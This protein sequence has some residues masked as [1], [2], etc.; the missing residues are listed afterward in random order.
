MHSALPLFLASPSFSG[1]SW[2]SVSQPLTRPSP[3]LTCNLSS[4]PQRKPMIPTSQQRQPCSPLPSSQNAWQGPDCSPALATSPA[5]SCCRGS[6]WNVCLH[7]SAA[8]HGLCPQ[9]CLC[10]RCSPCRGTGQ[11][12]DKEAALHPHTQVVPPPQ[13][14]LWPVVSP[15][16]TPPTSVRPPSLSKPCLCDS[17]QILLP[18]KQE[19]L[20]HREMGDTRAGGAHVP[21]PSS[22]ICPRPQRLSPSCKP[23]PVAGWFLVRAA[24]LP[25][26][27]YVFVIQSMLALNFLFKAFLP[28]QLAWASEAIEAGSNTSVSMLRVVLF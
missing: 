2:C 26:C 24:S 22:K 10:D 11:G 21:L 20:Q 17:R 16:T 3:D 19:H 1:P 9:P 18:G 28:L 5:G 25:A 6:R 14:S 7:W 4:S 23:F 12:H 13:H 8:P 15:S 27:H